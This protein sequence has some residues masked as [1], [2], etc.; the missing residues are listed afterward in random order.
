MSAL[1]KATLVIEVVYTLDGAPHDAV[2]VIPHDEEGRKPRGKA[3]K[4]RLI[5]ANEGESWADVLRG[6]GG[7][8][9]R[10]GSWDAFWELQ[11]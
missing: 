6:V 10:E 5:I 3:G 2:R 9:E 11:P 7:H 4:G 8:F 1:T